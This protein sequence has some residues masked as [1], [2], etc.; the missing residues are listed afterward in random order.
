MP[1]PAERPASGRAHVWRRVVTLVV[2]A[3]VLWALFSL[4]SQVD[5]PAVGDALGTLPWWSPPILVALLL[6]RQLLSS[7]PLARVVEGLGWKR[8]LHNEMSANL[9]ATLAPPPSDLVLRVGMFR[10]WGIDPVE[11]MAGVT[12]TTVVFWGVRFLAPVLGLGVVAI[13]GVERHEWWFAVGSLA[14]A[15]A[16]LVALTLVVRSERW[17]HTLGHLG[18]RIVTRFGRPADGA[19][20]AAAVGDFRSRVSASYRRHLMPSIA[21][22]LGGVVA[23]ALIVL[24]SLRLVGVG[25][26]LS[27]VE[28]VGVFLLLYP[29]TILPFL[30]LGVLDAA[31]IAAWLTDTPAVPEA[32]LVAG[33]LVWRAVSL[34]GTLAIGALSLAWWRWSTRR[35]AASA[36]G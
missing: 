9:V 31:L 35:S 20:W 13:R 32:T 3:A 26:S 21:L 14:I 23:E 34:G 33:T 4:G 24:A 11:G 27:A 29:L 2:V 8:A 12:L 19:V 36:R 5:W 7:A 16:I 18:A 15:A 10:S 30:G 22:G 17:A 1:A 28:I 6:L 25:A